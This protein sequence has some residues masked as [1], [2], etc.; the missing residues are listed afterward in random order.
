[1]SRGSLT[2]VG[3]NSL[4][5]TLWIYTHATAAGD[6]LAASMLDFR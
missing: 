5:I 6:D 4:A 2:R 1:M 3:Y